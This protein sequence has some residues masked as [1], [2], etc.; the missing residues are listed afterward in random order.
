LTVRTSFSAPIFVS[1]IVLPLEFFFFSFEILELFYQR[2]TRTASSFMLIFS[3][4][5]CFSFSS[6][7]SFSLPFLP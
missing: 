7:H 3:K 6:R 5:T 4:N 2:L 1:F